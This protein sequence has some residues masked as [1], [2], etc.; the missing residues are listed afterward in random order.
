[1][2]NNKPNAFKSP[3]PIKNEV[4][5]NSTKPNAHQ[6]KVSGSNLSHRQRF[7]RHRFTGHQGSDG[8][9]SGEPSRLQPP[10]PPSLR[11]NSGR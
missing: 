6:E 11:I 4:R 5:S 10:P 2:S 1:M 8:E 9:L 7:A 3:H